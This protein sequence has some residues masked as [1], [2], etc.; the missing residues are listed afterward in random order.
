VVHINNEM[1]GPGTHDEAMELL[2]KAKQATGPVLRPEFLPPL[3]R[4]EKH[5]PA[6]TAS[7]LDEFIQ[8]RLRA[9]S[10]DLYAEWQALTDR[11]LLTEVLRHAGNNLSQTARILGINRSTLRTKLAA[12]GITIE[13]PPPEE[14]PPPA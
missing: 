3:L 1:Y 12:L 14:D 5:T 7:V 6:L 9:G 11:H 2:T 4:G 8:E 10:G 13:K